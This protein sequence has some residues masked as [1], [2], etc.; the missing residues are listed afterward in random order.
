MTE[1][2]GHIFEC[3]DCGKDIAD[4]ET[5]H[6]FGCPRGMGSGATDAAIL[7]IEKDLAWRGPTGGCLKYVV[8]PREDAAALVE[9]LRPGIARSA[10]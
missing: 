6:L 9:R 8:I 5:K 2:E 4:L 10:A 3:P 7:K 1:K